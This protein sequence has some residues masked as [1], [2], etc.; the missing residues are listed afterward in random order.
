MHATILI[1]VD[2]SATISA[3]I[4]AG[5]NVGGAGASPTWNDIRPSSLLVSSQPIVRR[6]VTIVS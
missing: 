1:K 6:R 2:S 4:C 5:M 3:I